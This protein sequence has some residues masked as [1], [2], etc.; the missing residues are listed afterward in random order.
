MMSWKTMFSRYVPAA[1]AATVAVAAVNCPA[2]EYVN[3]A[4]EPSN[5]PRWENLPLNEPFGLTTAL[6][7][8]NTLLV[9]A[10]VAAGAQAI[11]AP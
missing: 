6:G 3:V 10:P 9:G 5:R 11:G 7:I 8:R 1:L 4:G 2:K